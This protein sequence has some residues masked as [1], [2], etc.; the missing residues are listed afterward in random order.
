[1]AARLL[2][3]KVQLRAGELDGAIEALKKLGAEN[4]AD[5]ELLATLGYALSQ[6]GSYQAS[7]EQYRAAIAASPISSPTLLNALGDVLLRAG[8]TS[9][10]KKA[11]QDSLQLDPDQPAVRLALAEIP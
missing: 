4:G 1:V 2:L 3:A 7:A 6:K 10:A 8:D 5:S 11:F 9:G